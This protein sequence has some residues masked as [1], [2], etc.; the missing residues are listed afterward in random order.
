MR[1]LL[2]CGALALSG[3]V[4]DRHSALPPVTARIPQSLKQACAGVVAI[5]DKDLTVAEASRLW[6]KDRVSLAICAKRHSALSKAASILEQ[7]K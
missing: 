5:P 1:V 3:C 7:P 2:L 4:T 6:A